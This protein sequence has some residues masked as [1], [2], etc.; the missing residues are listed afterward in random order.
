MREKLDMPFER[1]ERER[2]DMGCFEDMYLHALLALVIP[3]NDCVW[4]VLVCFA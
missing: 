4:E 3:C 1:H 2:V